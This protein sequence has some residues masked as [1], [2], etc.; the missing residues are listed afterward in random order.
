[1]ARP[2]L[3]RAFGWDRKAPSSSALLAV[4]LALWGVDCERPARPRR[5]N[6]AAAD[7]RPNMSTRG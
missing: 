4:S 1:V 7:L 2:V 6:S 3:G 5:D